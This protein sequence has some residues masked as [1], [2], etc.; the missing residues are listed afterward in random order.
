MSDHVT[1][2]KTLQLLSLLLEVKAM[3]LKWLK[4]HIL[5]FQQNCT[6]I[7]ENVLTTHL[8][9]ITTLDNSCPRTQLSYSN[10][11][12]QASLAFPWTWLRVFV[13]AI[14]SLSGVIFPQ[15]STAHTSLFPSS[16]CA[17]VTISEM[18]P[19][20][21]TSSFWYFCPPSLF[22][23]FLQSN[24]YLLIYYMINFFNLSN[25]H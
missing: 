8:F 15:L 7:S 16:F 17:N 3:S 14:P 22:Y 5:S 11:S 23:Y 2:L 12:I 18:R 10:L 4:G 24:Y 19:I 25:T 1:L 21:F 20:F 13:F 6:L 9:A